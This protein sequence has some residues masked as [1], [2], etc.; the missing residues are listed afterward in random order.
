MTDDEKTDV[1]YNGLKKYVRNFG[2]E[3]ALVDLC[4]IIK[5]ANAD[6]DNYLT[7]LHE[8][9][10]LA[11]SNYRKR[12][13]QGECQERVSALISETRRFLS[14]LHEDDHIARRG[15]ENMLREITKELRENG[16]YK[17][18]HQ[19]KKCFGNK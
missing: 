19:G 13:D 11:L 7:Q 12:Y 8:D 15:L 14:S 4:G 18:K 5:R 3:V 6:C 16:E 10:S 9:V 1:D 17:E 2:M